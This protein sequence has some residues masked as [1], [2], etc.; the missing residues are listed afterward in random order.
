LT[1]L[2]EGAPSEGAVHEAFNLAAVWGVG[3]I[4]YVQ[5][6]Q[7]AI[8]VPTGEQTRRER[9]PTLVEGFTYRPFAALDQLANHATRLRNRSRG[10]LTAAGDPAALPPLPPAGPAALAPAGDERRILFFLRRMFS[11]A[12]L[13]RE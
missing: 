11:D 8:S 13:I 9:R 12:M 5:N 4:F 6:N 1:F 2:G 7:Y 10:A 3:V